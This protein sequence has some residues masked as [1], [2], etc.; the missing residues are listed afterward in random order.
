MYS[1][2]KGKSGVKGTFEYFKLR[3]W[4]MLNRRTVNGSCPDQS[5]KAKAYLAKGIMLKV[6]REEFF[7]WCDTQQAL[8]EAL[9][10]QGETPS[11]DRINP[12]GHYELSNMRIISKRENSDLGRRNRWDA[13]KKSK[14][15][16]RSNN[17][18]SEEVK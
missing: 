12:E 16:K 7:R 3:R 13:Y 11:I 18:R 2:S 4:G 9:V 6:S 10:A 14:A 1:Y 15:A 8:V 5:P 17:E